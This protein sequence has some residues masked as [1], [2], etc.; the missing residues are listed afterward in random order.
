MS[1]ADKILEGFQKSTP[2]TD[3][4]HE[5]GNLVKSV[6]EKIDS[7]WKRVHKKH[8]KSKKTFESGVTANEMGFKFEKMM[9]TFEKQIEKK[10][11]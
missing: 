9:E 8:S 5:S 4:L 10:T 11:Y 3:D 6:V 2:K 1:K 7:I